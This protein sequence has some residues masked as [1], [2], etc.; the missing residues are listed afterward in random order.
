[1]P[2]IQQTPTKVIQNYSWRV[3][4]ALELRRSLMLSLII[5]IQAMGGNG[6]EISISLSNPWNDW[7]GGT[8]GK[9]RYLVQLMRA[10]GVTKPVFLDEISFICGFDA[11][12]SDQISVV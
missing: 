3:S 4:F 5:G 1:M 6:L 7:G 8:V 12:I 9:A 11:N 2:H 10:Y